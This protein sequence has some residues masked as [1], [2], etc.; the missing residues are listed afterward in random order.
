M[1]F[2]DPALCIDCGACI[3]VCPVNAIYLEANVPEDMRE[4]IGI[5]NQYFADKENARARVKDI[6]EQSSN[7]R[8]MRT[9]S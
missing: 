5:N 6:S 4:F 9:P 3:S 7:V 8:L 2:I 1:L